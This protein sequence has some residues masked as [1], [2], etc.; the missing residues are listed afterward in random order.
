MSDG[1]LKAKSPGSITIEQLIALND[2]IAALVRSGIPLERG[3]L[4]AGRDLRGKLGRIVHALAARLGRGETLVEALEGEKRSVPP[5]YRAVVEAGVRAGRLPVALEGMSRYVRGYSEARNAIGLALWYPLLVLCLAYALFVGLVVLVV[6]RFVEAF[7]SLRFPLPALLRWL[8]VL[9]PT[10]EYWWPVG[11]LLLVLLLLA[12]VATGRAAG[13]QSR[14][15]SWLKLFPWMR[16]LLSDYETANFCELLALLLEHRVAYPRALVLA[17]E[18]TGDARLIAGMCELAAAVTR[19]EPVKS[20][21]AAIDQRAILPMLRWVLAT[22]QD[23]GSLVAGL[24][25]L[26][27]LYRKR[28]VYQAEKLYVFLP[29]VLLI[30]IGAGATLL[31]ALA[32]FIPVIEMLRELTGPLA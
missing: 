3:L 19:G 25:H 16:S 30:A 22:G 17:A 7:V 8:S 5:L 11:P 32:L 4:M 15:W 23:Q 31:Y 13:F 29:L 12:W 14:G 20:A 6:P 28:A 21:V 18:P 2:E 24:R 10:V 27:D 9:G 1:E 26:T